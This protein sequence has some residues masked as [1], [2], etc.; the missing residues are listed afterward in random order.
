VTGLPP[1]PLG[2]LS[3]HPGPFAA[4][5][6]WGHWEGYREGKEAGGR[7]GEGRK[8]EYGRE[9]IRGEGTDRGRERD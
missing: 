6:G 9:E 5:K 2:S 3:A 8:R 1:D 7:E 4:L